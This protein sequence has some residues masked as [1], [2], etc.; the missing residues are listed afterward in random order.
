MSEERLLRHIFERSADLRAAFPH[1]LVG[2]GDDCAVLATG[3]TTLLKVDQVVEGRHFV[4]GTAVDLIARKAIARAVSDLAGM[5]GTPRAALAAAT[6]PT[7]YSRANDLFTACD[8]WARHFGCPLV[9]G[10]ISGGPTLALAV[11][12]IGAP[13]STRGPVLRSTAKPGD[14]V[15]VTG[16]LG[17]SFD[18]PSGLG[19]HL[20]FQPR[21]AEAAWLAEHLGDDLHAMMDLSDGLGIDGGRMGRASCARVDIDGR[22]LPLSPYTKGWREAVSDGEDYELLFTTS[23]GAAVPEEI[24]GT[25]VTR[26]GVVVPPSPE[27]GCWIL[28]PTGEVARGDQLGWEH[29]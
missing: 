26:I 22:S 23:P 9:G 20:T 14:L 25:P 7:G 24:D 1:V 4:P 17:G 8:R 15:W 27:A 12:L 10:D 13:H 6:I 11:T 2:P 29:V 19:R 5:A 18:K 21:V 3:P 28:G 16:M